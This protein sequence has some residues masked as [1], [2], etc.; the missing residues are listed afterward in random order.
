MKRRIGVRIDK[1]RE[2][3]IYRLNLLEAQ[4][5]QPSLRQPSAGPSSYSSR[6]QKNPDQDHPERALREDSGHG[7][8]LSMNSHGIQRPDTGGGPVLAGTFS[9]APP[10]WMAHWPA[11]AERNCDPGFRTPNLISIMAFFSNS[12]SAP[13]PITLEYTDHAN[14]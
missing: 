13:R 14:P 5:I 3:Q 1:R 8:T 7:S 6:G 2:I 12:T 10:S 4:G 9:S 11:D